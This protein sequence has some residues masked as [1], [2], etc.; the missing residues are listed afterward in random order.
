MLYTP[1]TKAALR[2]CFDAHKEQVDKSGLPYVFHPFH[3]A[4][5][6]ETEHETCVALLHDVMEDTPL[7]PADLV[8]AGI[9]EEYVATCNLMTH[10]PGVPYL[11]YVRRLA[12]D[13]VARKVKLADLAHNSDV[14]RLDGDPGEA[15]L[16]RLAKY[17]GARELL[18]A[19]ERIEES[20]RRLGRYQ[21]CLLG[22]AVGDALGYAVEFDSYARIVG[23]YG[24]GGIRSLE[25]PGAHFS[26]DTQMTLFTANGLLV[27]DTHRKLEGSTSR[28]ASYV[29]SAYLD[30]LATQSWGDIGNPGVCWLLDVDALHVGRAPGNTCMSALYAGGGGSMT[31]RI[32]DSKG[33]GGVMRV[34]PWGLFP[35]RVVREGDDATCLV[36]EGAAMGALTHGHPLGWIPAGVLC[37][38]VN[39]C[40][41][42]VADGC[43]DPRGELE[44]IVRDAI[45]LLPSWFPEVPQDA[46]YMAQLLDQAIALASC[47]EEDQP[48]ILQL[49]GGWVGEQALAIAVFSALRHADDFG[50]A[51]I[52]AANHDGDSDSTAA[53]CGNIMGA[54]LGIEAVGPEW[55]EVELRDVILEVARDLCDRCQMTEN[56]VYYDEV[57]ADKYCRYKA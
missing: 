52:S 51:I 38:L 12:K 27:G 21:G 2:L 26:D 14:S 32:N 41:F 39:R 4:E 44:A 19:Y 40:A 48:C 45:R 50:E 33:C 35:G 46:S 54:L 53:I 28:Y 1:A 36:R 17:R 18:E 16:K 57:W 7:G 24:E 3:L 13:P 29:N 42:D 34:A 47:D 43:D 9:P 55:D 30:W 22:G 49:G 6:M 23:E 11:E 20:E 10:A 31:H 25:G 15:D 8:A 56:G 5:Q 37:Y